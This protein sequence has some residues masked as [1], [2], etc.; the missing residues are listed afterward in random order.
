MIGPSV[1]TTSRVIVA[2]MDWSVR[3]F[4]PYS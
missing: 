2:M 1:A 3:K 4:W